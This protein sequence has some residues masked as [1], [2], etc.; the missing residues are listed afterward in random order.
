VSRCG[1]FIAVI[2]PGWL[3]ARNADGH[4]RLDDASDF[5][6]VEIESALKRDIRVIPV[7]VD[8]ASMPRASELPPSLEPL[9]R[10]N[11]LEIAHHRF[12]ADCDRLA[13]AIRRALGMEPQSATSSGMAPQTVMGLAAPASSTVAPSTDQSS[14]GAPRSRLSWPEVLFSFRG[15]VSRKQFAL[16]AVLMLGFAIAVF[17]LFFAMTDQLFSALDESTQAASK[18]LRELLEKRMTSV[19]SLIILWPSWAL[20]LKRLHD[21]GHGWVAFTPVAALDLGSTALDLADQDDLSDKVMLVYLG[22]I[23]MLA[24]IKGVEGSNKY[25]ADPVPPP[26]A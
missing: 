10:R 12:A 23:V 26:K 8:G 20:I 1:A 18:A 13:D 2:G 14:A 5:V 3:N 6:R 11:A 24:V 17:I 7:L 21:I 22:I 4:R 25:G 19:V 16:G 15:R 9:S